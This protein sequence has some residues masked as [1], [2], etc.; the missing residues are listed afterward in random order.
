MKIRI[1]TKPDKCPVC[2]SKKIATYLR[3]MP[4]FT[5]K[6]ER[7]IDEGK[8]VL[9]GCIVTGDD[10]FCICTDCNTEFYRQEN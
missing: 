6:L 10:S 4:H 3:G 1:A 2:G 9:K 5:K 7:E 8:I